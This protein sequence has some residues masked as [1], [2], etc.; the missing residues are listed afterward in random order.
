[1][2]SWEPEETAREGSR[3]DLAAGGGVQVGQRRGQGGC[4][5]RQRQTTLVSP[6]PV[7]GDGGG[8]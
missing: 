5:H 7:E 4:E 6:R 3:A 8:I 2:V 1:M